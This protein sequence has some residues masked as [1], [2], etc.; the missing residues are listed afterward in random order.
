MIDRS[1][2][3][4]KTEFLGCC[5]MGSGGGGDRVAECQ[6]CLS[7]SL[8]LPFSTSKMPPPS[9]DGSFSSRILAILSLQRKKD[10]PF[11]PNSNR[12]NERSAREGKGRGRGIRVNTRNKHGMARLERYIERQGQSH[13]RGP[14]V[15]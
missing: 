9:K 4:C 15:R 10:A 3:V 14:F 13:S 12:I 6:S 5:W 1:P 2:R 11:P 7:L 8:P